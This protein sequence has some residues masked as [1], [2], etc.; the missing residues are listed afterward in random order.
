[1]KAKRPSQSDIA[2]SAGV[3]RATVSLVLRGG[4]GLA[5]ETI[6][7]VLAVASR[8]GYR[9]NSLVE[10]IKS[11]KTRTVGLFLHPYDSYWADVIN[12]VCDRLAEARHTGVLL[13]DR[14]KAMGKDPAFALS[15]VHRALDSWCDAVI[16]WP[17]FAALYAGHMEEFSSRNVPVVTIDHVLPERFKADAVV[18]DEMGI[19]AAV[20]NHLVSLGHTNFLI[21]GG[22]AGTGWADARVAAIEAHLATDPSIRCQVE[23]IREVENA[24]GPVLQHIRRADRPTAVLA[25]T[26]HFAVEAYEA[27]RLAGLR[28]PEDVS[29]TG[30]ADL[31]FAALLQP[32]LTTVKQDG[33]EVGRRAAQLAL[34]RSVGL[35]AGPP[36]EVQVP[37][38]L[39]ARSSTASAPV[40]AAHS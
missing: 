38:T 11:G 22:P 37:T 8:M 36:V 23:R 5:Q 34:E 13:M 1:M 39:V 29:V 4:S 25:C 40:H 12:G 21:V 15:Q 19:A 33:Y 17:F 10:G 26:D 32:P 30:V 16:L 28:V 27:A 14:T 3:S 9:P 31:N 18:A 7:R 2:K 24:V 20:V 35:L 6:D